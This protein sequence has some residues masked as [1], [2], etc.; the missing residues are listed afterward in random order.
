MTATG[1]IGAANE[2]DEARRIALAERTLPAQGRGHLPAFWPDAE[3]RRFLIVHHGFLTIDLAREQLAARVGDRAPSRSAIGR[4]W[5][6]LDR[7]E[8]AQ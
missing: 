3:V 6:A 5:Q 1:G 8:L 4:F 7:L 2:V